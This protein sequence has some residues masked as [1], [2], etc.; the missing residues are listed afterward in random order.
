M[1]SRFGYWDTSEALGLDYISRLVKEIT[2]DQWS[3]PVPSSVAS[4]RNR[5]C[6]ADGNEWEVIN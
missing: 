4:L 3:I 2:L 5:I 6:S 1:E